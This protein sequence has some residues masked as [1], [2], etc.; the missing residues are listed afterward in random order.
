MGMNLAQVY[1]ANPITTIG[2]TDLLYVAQTGT[3]DAGISGASLLALF[4]SSTLTSAHIYVGNASNVATSVA[5]SGD[6]TITNAG[7]VSVTGIGH[8]TSG[9]LALANGGTNAALT[10]VAGGLA[11]STASAFAF[12]AAGTAGQLAQSAGASAPGWTTSTY[13]ATNA[14]NTLLYASSANVMAALATANSATL[15]TSAGGVPSLSQT[16]PSAVQTNITALGTQGQALNMGSHQINFVTDPT[17]AQD[18]ATKNYVDLNALNGT[19]VYAASTGSLGTV[20]QSGAGVGATLTNAGAQATFSLDSV[21]PPVGSN[22]LIKN[23]STGATA[24]NE[25]VYTVTN[26]GSGATNWVLT[27]ATNFDTAA[28][29]NT[30]GLIVVQNGSTLAGTAWY[31]AATITTVDTTNF[32]FSQFGTTGTVTSVATSGL[33][34]GGPITSSGTITVTAATKAN[35]ET[36]TSTTTAVTPAVQQYHPSAC[37]AWGQVSHGASPTFFAS[38]NC[39]SVVQ[40]A[41]GD[42]TITF[43]TNF[44]SANFAVMLGGGSQNG[45]SY[46]F[47]SVSSQTSSTIRVRTST[48]QGTFVGTDVDFSFACFGTQ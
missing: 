27:R 21:N 9:V 29:I 7:V 20:T 24:A 4:P 30:T 10:A 23:T 44:T 38:Y 2:S 40:N 8:I 32:S 41:T 5:M 12:S 36:A 31:N 22:V 47:I 25:G 18:A 1:T 3:T 43:T 6:A 35:Q 37:Q 28:E 15:I 11:Y 16:L 34:T 14:V 17:S 46:A 45:A 13:P 48:T 19:S 42:Y 33:A 26:A 39:A